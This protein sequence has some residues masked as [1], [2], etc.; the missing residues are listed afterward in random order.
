MV[1]LVF[2][3]YPQVR[4]TICT[5]VSL[6]DSTRVSSVFTTLR[7]SSPTFESRLACSN[8]NPSQKIRI[9]QRCSL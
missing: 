5:S 3:P 4:R 6:R 1:R 7:H 8:A 2:S 9:G